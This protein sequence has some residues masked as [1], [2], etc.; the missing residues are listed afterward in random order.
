MSSLLHSTSWLLGRFAAAAM[1][2][3]VASLAPEAAEAATSKPTDPKLEAWFGKLTGKHRVVFDAPEPN[4]GF[5]VIWPRVYLLTTEA[6][7]PERAQARW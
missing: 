7:T 1:G 2:I 3:G 6:A 5:P 4:G